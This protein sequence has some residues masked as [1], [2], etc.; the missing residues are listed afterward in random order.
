MDKNYVT[1]L[2]LQ[3]VL[4]LVQALVF[5]HIVLFDVAIAFVFIYIIIRLPMD[6]NTNWLLTWG[7]L[8]GVVMDLFSDTPGVNAVACTVL[9]MVKSP[10]LYAYVPRDDRTKNIYPSLAS[11][12]F[13]IYGKYLLSMTLIYCVLAFSLEYFNFADVKEIS[14]MSASSAAFTFIILLSVDSLIASHREKRL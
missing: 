7:F 4:I 5:N 8:A 12:G 11:L 13:S 14:I 9:A 1:N 6:M 3:F 10:M 2:L